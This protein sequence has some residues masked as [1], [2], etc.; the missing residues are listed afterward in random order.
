MWLK[1]Y[2]KLITY[3]LPCKVQ[4]TSI[5]QTHSKS[6]SHWCK[7]FNVCLIILRS[8]AVVQRCSVKKVFCKNGVLRNFRPEACYFVKREALAQLFSCEFCEISQNTYS[9]RTPP[10]A[11]FVRTR[12]Y[13]SIR[14]NKEAMWSSTRSEAAT[15]SCFHKKVFWKYEA[16]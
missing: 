10:V 7:I 1:S 14:L 6:C 11:A 5:S 15:Q 3:F 8:E 4:W 13:F 12:L 2:A 9:E 16:N